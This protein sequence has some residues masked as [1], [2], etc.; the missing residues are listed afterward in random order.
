[1]SH[2]RSYSLD[3]LKPDESTVAKQLLDLFGRG[4]GG[5]VVV[6]RMPAQQQVAH[7]TANQ[8]R[9][10]A[11]FMQTIKNAQ[12][13][14][15]DV[16]ARYSVLLARNDTQLCKRAFGLRRFRWRFGY[17]HAAAASLGAINK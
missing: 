12:R 11:A 4:A 1:M 3:T 15:A 9:A 6:L 8:E 13:I 17:W 16:L 14:G 7:R 10:I 5:H 2:K